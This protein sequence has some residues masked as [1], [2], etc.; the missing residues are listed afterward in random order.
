MD[1]LWANDKLSRIKF[2][3]AY[4]GVGEPPTPLYKREGMK[5]AGGGVT[6]HAPHSS[7]ENQY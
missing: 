5:R 2:M 3:S 1:T 7:S 4:K 6:K